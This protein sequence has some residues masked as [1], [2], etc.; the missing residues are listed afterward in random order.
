MSRRRANAEDADVAISAADMARFYRNAP[1]AL[2][3]RSGLQRAESI[4]GSLELVI[5]GATPIVGMLW[6]DW[7]A[8]QLLV[9]LVAAM[10]VGIF[11]DMA[12]LTLA[13]RGV[14]E[15]GATHYDDWHVWVVVAALRSGR[16][17]APRSHLEAKHQ[18][19]DGMMIDLVVGAF[20][21]AL[22]GAAI[23]MPKEGGFRELLADCGF[24]LSVATL[25]AYQAA[26]TAWEIVRHRRAGAAAGPVQA[27]PGARGVGLFLL[28]FVTMTLGDPDSTDGLMARRVMLAVNGTIVVVGV[29]NAAAWGWLRRETEWLREYL[30]ERP[31]EPL[32][33]HVEGK[34][35]KRK[36]GGRRA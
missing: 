1:G 2:A 13:G 36:R 20:S 8:T 10:C 35:R 14:K 29:L 18:T 16:N 32:V 28:M 5:M 4:V 30:R 6:F 9:F 24:W 15:F 3:R 7:S 21:T 34:K 23:G 22:I 19:G 27:T 12:R 26:T 31:A 33:P 25:V 11:C 17:T